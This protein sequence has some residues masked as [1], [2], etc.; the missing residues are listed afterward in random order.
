MALFGYVRIYKPEMKVREYEAYKGVYCTLCREIGRDNGLHARALLSY[1][2]TFVAMLYM[3]L[4]KQQPCFELKSCVFNPLKRCSFCNCDRAAFEL[5]G[6]MT[7]LMFHYKVTDNIRDSGAIGRVLWRAARLVSSPM[8]KRARRRY[9]ELDELIA[10]CMRS[11]YDVE[12]SEDVSIDSAAEPTAVLLREL[13]QMLSEDASDRVVLRDFGYFLGRW[14]YLID[15]FDDI[16]KDIKESSFNPFVIR[17]GLTKRD[18]DDDSE[19][20]RQAREYANE[21][22]N[23]TVA[24]AIKA[25]GLLD[26]GQYAPIFDNILYLG[27]GESQRRALHEKEMQ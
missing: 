14:I 20:L 17:F 2:Y 25:F 9:P 5:T 19:R 12:H 18:I 11:Q 26:V 22:L 15:A 16:E 1:D 8:R 7:A 24:R 10:Q 6:G 3:A 4:H 21:C 13:A 23:M 27:L